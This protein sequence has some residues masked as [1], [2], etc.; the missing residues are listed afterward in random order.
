MATSF[1]YVQ[2]DTGPQIKLT[3]TES[4][5]GSPINLTSGTVTLHFRAAGEETV[6]FSR[7]LFIDQ[8]TA[9][10]GKQFYSGKRMI[11]HKKLA[12]TKAKLKLFY[13]P[14]FVKPFLIF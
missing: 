11:L 4:D 10:N 6:L 3:L 7:Q 8:N 14:D 5:T 9:S 1:K 2:G 12:L 13:L